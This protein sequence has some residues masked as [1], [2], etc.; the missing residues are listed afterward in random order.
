MGV[1]F[2]QPRAFAADALRLFADGLLPLVNFRLNGRAFGR[3]AIQ[4]L[5]DLGDGRLF[6]LLLLDLGQE[7]FAF[8]LQS[9]PLGLEFFLFGFEF[10]L[11]LEQL[12]GRFGR[13][14]V[15]CPPSAFELEPRPLALDFGAA[16]LQLAIDGIERLPVGFER[17]AGLLQLG[18][19]R[20]RS[21]ISLATLRLSRATRRR[22]S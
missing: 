17:L 16:P 9:R 15:R 20:A 22:P 5:A 3:E 2:L 12:G 18:R 21:R 10:L 1:L 6:G 7:L 11:A 4:L 14:G 13:L 8:A 19:L